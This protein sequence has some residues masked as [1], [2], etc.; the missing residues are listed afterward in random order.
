MGRRFTTVLS[1][2]LGPPH[3]WSHR[4][5]KS[6]CCP[7]SH[8][9]W[10]QPLQ[11]PQPTPG[12]DSCDNPVPARQ[13]SSLPNPAPTP[14]CVLCAPP[15]FAQAVPKPVF[16]SQKSGPR[17]VP[18]QDR[19]QPP[20]P[21]SGTGPVSQASLCLE[22]RSI[23]GLGSVPCLTLFR[24]HHQVLILQAEPC[25]PD[26]TLATHCLQPCPAPRLGRHPRPDPPL[27]GGPSSGD[28]LGLRARQLKPWHIQSPQVLRGTSSSVRTAD[29]QN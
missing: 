25:S 18:V 15:A 13:C 5:P 29:Q 12:C 20:S 27:P 10:P 17:S 1:G 3:L 7:E 22:G 21:P 26:G 11:V 28:S 8:W 19:R 14:G 4:L 16:P 9:H 2:P 24:G 6:R 23:P